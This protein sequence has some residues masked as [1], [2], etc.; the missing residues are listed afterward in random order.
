MSLIEVF[1]NLHLVAERD[2]M[3]GL[4]RV[5]RTDR[6]FDRVEDVDSSY[7]AMFRTINQVSRS[8]FSLLVDLRYSPARSDPPF[9]LMM[10]K[11]R[12]LL[13]QGFRRCAILVRSSLG[14]RQVLQHTRQDGFSVLVGNI[15]AD[16]LA[17]LTDGKYQKLD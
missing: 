12:P 16:L 8:R 17:Y 5:T 4:L 10:R 15:E 11:V 9:D 14:V 3:H 6:E 1:R 2:S 13:F 7:Q